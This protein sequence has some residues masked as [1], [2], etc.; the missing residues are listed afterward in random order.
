MNK[1]YIR[2][3]EG[4]T[5]VEI[6]IVMLI[7]GL[8]I[9][10]IMGPLKTQLE[11]IDRKDAEK[12]IED[13]KEAM[14]GFA[15]RMDRLPCPDTTG[16]GQED[17]CANDNGTVPWATLGVSPQDPWNR[18]LTYHVDTSFTSMPFGLSST[19]NITVRATSA[20]ATV[21]SDIPAIIVSHGKNWV[22]AGDANEQENSDNDADFVDKNHINQGYD[23]FVGWVNIN[24]LIA[25]MVSANKLP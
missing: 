22:S 6:A 11:N 14:I 15:I 17:S 10:G 3:Q 7:F 1:R 18:P 23:D 13:T 24:K 12:L 19:G 5:L 25:K 9:G 8:I 4:F 2:K 21:A 20:G 16:D